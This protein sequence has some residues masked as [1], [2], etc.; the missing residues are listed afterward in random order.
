M[1]EAGGA[2]A[3]ALFRPLTLPSGVVLKNRLAKAAMS[4][5]LGDGRG[6][7]TGAQRRLYARWA[8]GG[9]ALSV[10]GEVQGDP[11]FAE[12]PGNLVLAPGADAAGFA[13]LARCGAADG[14]RLWL[15]L[16]HAGALA[17]P[18]IGTPKGPSALDLPG[19]ACAAL[20]QAEVAALPA[21]FARTAAQAERL[22]F[23]GVELH[24]AHGFLLSQ[25]L[26]PL[27]NRRGDA[28]GGPLANR[29]RLLIE[30]VEAVRDA[31]GAGF[32]V[33]VKLNATDQLAGGFAEDEALAVVAA[34]EATGIDLIDISGGTYFPGAAAASDRRTA[35]P[36]FGAFAAAARQRTRT[37]L[38]LTGGF[39]TRAEAAAAVAGGT[40]DVVG[41]ARALVLD[42]ALPRRW[43]TAE[44]GDPGFPRF[45]ESPE[46]GITAWYTMRLT[47]LAEGGASAP[48]DPA[49]A[50]DAYRAR[51]AARVALWRARFGPPPANAT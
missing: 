10:V 2:A 43:R 45:G 17:H 8:A 19:L 39:K 21:L 26:S 18:P 47:A 29:M 35:G 24:A 38:M 7:P 11:H 27:F 48:A 41:L 36:Y 16:G 33:A 50:L 51:D 13:A 14:S 37:P 30:T 28:Y 6:N 25:F 3:A 46:G 4:D 42:P 31:V 34:L 9:A 12:K 15:Q 20:T 5:S 49:A 22:G 32:A 23:G 40:V 1:A 44:G